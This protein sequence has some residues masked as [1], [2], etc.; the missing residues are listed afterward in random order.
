[1][2]ETGTLKINAWLDGEKEKIR[3]YKERQEKKFAEHVRKMHCNKLKT[4]LLK[5][6]FDVKEEAKKL[7]KERQHKAKEEKAV[8]AAKEILSKGGGEETR[9]SGL[10]G[11]AKIGGFKVKSSDA[12]YWLKALETND[13]Q[14]EHRERQRLRRIQRTDP[15]WRA[16]QD[17]EEGDGGSSWRVRRTRLGTEFDRHPESQLTE[18]APIDPG[19]V[20]EL[21]ET[22]YG[23]LP[24][25]DPS[26][27]ETPLPEAREPA[28]EED[29]SAP[30]K[31]PP[32]ET[33]APDEDQAQALRRQ[34]ELAAW[35]QQEQEH[36]TAY[37]RGL[38]AEVT[39][40]TAQQTAVV[41]RLF[42]SKSFADD[43]QRQRNSMSEQLADIIVGL[44]VPEHEKTEYE[45]PLMKDMDEW[46]E[47]ERCKKPVP[48]PTPG[49]PALKAWP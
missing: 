13:P 41:D 44:P 30:K 21:L 27:E 8:K 31:K 11:E 38:N 3:K 20:V 16:K 4:N 23:P 42:A 37:G 19:N 18:L 10:L 32:P 22:G 35:L 9:R 15:N 34:A 43:C 47:C 14:W 36:I 7:Y 17:N 46:L 25:P 49:K 39:T 40:W 1:M 2:K 6:G 33:E 5:K 12:K 48:K 45:K 29:P 26:G 24:N 28:P